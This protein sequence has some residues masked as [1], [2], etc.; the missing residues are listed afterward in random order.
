MRQNYNVTI[1]LIQF[2]SW[3]LIVQLI[4][5]AVLP[6]TYH[7]FA[8]LADRGY[9][10]AKSLGILLVGFVLWLGYSYGLLRNETGGAWLALL[11]V[12]GLSWFAV[13]QKT[14][15]S[16]QKLQNANHPITHFLIHW[17]Y[18]V[19]I[20]LLFLL[21]F[22]SWAYVRA[23]D[24]AAD[25][26]EKPMDLMFMNSLWV[27][28]T[29]PPQDAWLSGHPISYYYFGYWLLITLGR[30]A[31][32]P[33]E[34]AY[35]LGQACW[36]GLLLIGCMGVVYNLLRR[37]QQSG[38]AA[39][40]GGLVGALAVGLMGNLQAVVEWLRAQGIGAGLF[41]ALLSPHNFPPDVQPTGD[42]LIS[43]QWWSGWAWRTSRVLEDLTLRGD[44][45]EVIDEI[46]MFSY[47]LGD[48]HPH[49]LAMP[50]VL[51]VIGLI[52]NLFFA[53]A[54][55][56]KTEATP[57][58]QEEAVPPSRW[59]RWRQTGQLL[60][61]LTPLGGVGALYL[62]I[63]LGSLIFLNTWDLPP[64]WLLLLGT[65]VMLLGRAS[66]AGLFRPALHWGEVAIYALVA[67]GM[68]IG[69]AVL[70]YLPYLLTAQ[71]QAGGFLPNL[72][73]PTRFSQFFLMF[74]TQLCA[75]LALIGLAWSER[76][77]TRPQLAVMGGAVLGIPL[78]FVLLSALLALNT[79]LGQTVLGSLA[80]PDGATSHAPF[81]WQR[82]SRQGV[83]FLLVG[84]ALASVLALLWQRLSPAGLEAE[85]AVA[86]RQGL[87]FALLLA[88]CGL[89]LVYA[90]EFIYL[91]DNFGTR[92]NTVFKFYYQAWLLL[93]LSLGYAVIQVMRWPHA[94]P[95][96]ARGGG[97][98][99]VV[100]L[101]LGL[102]Y[103]LANV[104][105]R[106][107][108]FINP[109][110]TFNTL[111]YI[112]DA[113]SPEQAALA[114][115]R[116]NTAPDALIVQ[117]A[118]D[119]YRADTSRVSAA[120]GRPTLLGWGGHESQWRGKRYGAM[121]QGRPEA[122]ELIYLRGSSDEIAQELSKWGIDYVYYGPA[123]RNKYQLPPGAE[124]RLDGV[125]DLVFEQGDVR[126]YR[127]RS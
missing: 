120:T 44:H 73:N 66:A 67:G 89:L 54:L 86:P 21:T 23:H 116:A 78:L 3:Y 72:F 52:Q 121:A 36:L 20:E 92:M 125:M 56:K 91:R 18:V 7:L 83:T 104:Y 113:N 41:R 33:P 27:S 9:A 42:W 70:L 122:L 30:L 29:Y 64:Y 84:G 105:G 28:P 40:A 102:T 10:F 127:T 85:P 51:L 22:A 106:T 49:V 96:V 82:W 43:P 48:N 100:G 76:P 99:A 117:A 101:V 31:G 87:Y 111:A 45:I 124:R 108:G 71:S 53:P 1:M 4:T 19:V 95:W 39:L 119:S 26:T 115:I 75:L 38:G 11:I 46:P 50:L 97:L 81:I 8:N 94:A 16:G 109:N 14:E 12:A 114:W 35:N 74:G 55:L 123:E 5:L 77:P 103:P 34:L 25:H 37:D 24:P 47:A 93:G 2:L 107:G 58:T 13:R 98:V 90:P 61:A 57:A 17:H 79:A 69:G 126:I 80:L 65:L 59:Q 6:L 110:P 63:A 68:V 60:L 32:Q 88:A 62:T 112:G 118:G 15:A